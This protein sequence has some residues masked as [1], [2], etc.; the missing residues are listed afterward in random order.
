MGSGRMGE[1][2]CDELGGKDRGGAMTSLVLAFVIM[3]DA[4]R[5]GQAKQFIVCQAELP[6]PGM[7]MA[8]VVVDQKGFVYQHAPRLQ[9]VHDRR[10]KRSEQVEEDE[11]RVI[12]V[13][14][15]VGRVVR[16]SFQIPGFSS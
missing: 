2:L 16:C 12:L 13:A 15:Q 7:T 6:P 4:Q 3:K 8:E 1:F 14:T 11:D 10:K 5:G 9:C